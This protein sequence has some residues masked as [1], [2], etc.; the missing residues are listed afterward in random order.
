MKGQRTGLILSGGGARAAYQVGVLKAI[1]EIL[2]RGHYNPFDII[3][4]TSAGA[5]NGIALASYAEA[6]R[7]GIRHME[8]IWRHFSCDQ[9]YRTDFRGMSHSLAR[10]GRSLIIGRGYKNDP[11][12][13][14]D[15]TPLR[16]LLS[17][18]VNFADIQQAIKD[19]YL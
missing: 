15:N 6:Y 7:R 4:G 16:Q 13:L 19:Q 12:S 2:P 1:H 17:E 9:I 8:R 10:M 14:L 11:V 5:I 3:S 18:V